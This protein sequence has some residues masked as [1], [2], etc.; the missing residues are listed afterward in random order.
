VSLVLQT[1]IF[2][3]HVMVTIVPEHAGRR[4]VDGRSQSIW[5]QVDRNCKDGWWQVTS[6]AD[7]PQ[8]QN[9]VNNQ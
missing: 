6:T 7:F 9:V 1:L 4:F 2:V 5:Q 3:C 8:A